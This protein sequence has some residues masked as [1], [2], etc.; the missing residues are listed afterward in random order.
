MAVKVPFPLSGWSLQ[1]QQ[2]KGC[3]VH[4]LSSTSISSGSPG[5]PTLDRDPLR[6]HPIIFWHLRHLQDGGLWNCLWR[7]ETSCSFSIIRQPFYIDDGDYSST[8]A[9]GLEKCDSKSSTVGKETGSYCSHPIIFCINTL[10]KLPGI[11]GMIE[12]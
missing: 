9:F 11:C 10:P 4:A 6:P 8:S 2:M 3:S 7:R 12:Q 1:C 5:A